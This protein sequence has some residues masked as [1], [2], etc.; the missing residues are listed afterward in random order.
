MDIVNLG[1]VLKKN[2]VFFF[3]WDDTNPK[4]LD[5]ILPI[6]AGLTG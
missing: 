1:F 2:G 5:P 6:K 3:L 4:D